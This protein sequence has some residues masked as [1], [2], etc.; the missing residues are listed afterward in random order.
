MTYLMDGCRLIFGII[1]FVILV[2]AMI[3]VPY[4]INK[5]LRLGGRGFM[6]VGARFV[7]RFAKK[8]A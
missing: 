6:N 1:V 8:Q 3:A 2:N 7:N 5:G 4:V